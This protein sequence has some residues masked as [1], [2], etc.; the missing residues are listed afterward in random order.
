MSDVVVLAVDPDQTVL[1]FVRRH[2]TRREYLF[3]GAR[4]G[5]D[6]LRRAREVSPNVVVTRV[7][8]SDM[9]G[10]DLVGRFRSEVDPVRSGTG[11]PILLTGL[12]GQEPEAVAALE[13]GA[14]GVLFFPFTEADLLGR[15]GSLIRWARRPSRKGVLNV[16]KVAVDFDR[17]ELVRPH[18]H[19]LT[20]SELEILRWLLSPPGR[21]VTRRQIQAGGD[22]AVDVHVAS[23][24][25]KLGRESGRIETLRGIGYRFRAAGLL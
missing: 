23:L 18:A 1:S 7:R 21:A 6:A 22:R 3:C 24:R 8:L 16:G 19:P 12:R 17:G 15:L 4:R 14:V 20:A 11:T 10:A 13:R 2:V 9:S 25:A 5:E